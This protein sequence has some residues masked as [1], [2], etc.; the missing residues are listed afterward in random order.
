MGMGMGMGMGTQCRALLAMFK[1]EV[2]DALQTRFGPS[3][4][5][6]EIP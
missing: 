1:I 5:K 4:Y 2:F 3:K 6:V